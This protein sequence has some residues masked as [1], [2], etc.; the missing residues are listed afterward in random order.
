LLVRGWDSRVTTQA[1]VEEMTSRRASTTL[2]VL[3]GG[4]AVHVDDPDGFASVVDG[5]ASVVKEFLQGL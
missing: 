2:R 3:D 1:A 4:H 5:F